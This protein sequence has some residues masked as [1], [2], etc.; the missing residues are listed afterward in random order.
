LNRLAGTPSNNADA[1]ASIPIGSVIM[2]AAFQSGVYPIDFASLSG[3]I[4]IQI[5][6]NPAIRFVVKNDQALALPAAWTSCYMTGMTIDLVDSAFAVRNA[7]ANNPTLIY[8]LPG[9]YI[10]SVNYNIPTLNVGTA[11]TLNLQSAPA[12]MLSAIILNVRPNGVVADTYAGGPPVA[13]TSTGW[14]GIAAGTQMIHANSVKLS[15]LQLLYGGQSLV[16]CQS[17]QEILAMNTQAFDGD[18]LYFQEQYS[19]KTGDEFVGAKVMDSYLYVLPFGYNMRKILSGKHSENLSGYAGT[20]LQLSFTVAQSTQ[21]NQAANYQSIRDD[22]VIQAA[23][24]YVVTITYI[25]DALVEVSQGTVDM[26]I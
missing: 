21:R 10:S 4:L 2:N 18:D 15:T 19:I 11:Y 24:P 26:Q 16:N 25:I 20:S 17:F 1:F 12:G 9:K 3:P 14:F 8:S 6:W 5:N 22:L 13:G 7:M 23:Q